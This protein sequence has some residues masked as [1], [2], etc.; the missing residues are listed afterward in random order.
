MYSYPIN[1]IFIKNVR[2]QYK[3]KDHRHTVTAE[4]ATTSTEDAT[5]KCAKCMLSGYIATVPTCLSE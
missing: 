1:Y 2:K 4:L 5:C 3:Y